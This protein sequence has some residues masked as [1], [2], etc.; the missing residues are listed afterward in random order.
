NVA[1]GESAAING[2]EFKFNTAFEDFI[3][4]GDR[5]IG[6]KTNQGDFLS[7]WVVNAAGLYS[8]VV[9]HK[10]GVRPEFKIQPRKGEYFVFDRADVL[11][12]IVSLPV[13][14]VAW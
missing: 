8:D 2:V 3:M 13:S 6:I 7:R 9:M 10:A 1:A 5:I 11:I 12:D 14:P 4:E